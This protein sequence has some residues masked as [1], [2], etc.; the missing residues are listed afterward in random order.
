MQEGQWTKAWG[1][2]VLHYVTR[3]VALCGAKVQ[4]WHDYERD[5]FIYSF[6]GVPLCKKCKEK[7]NATRPPAGAES[8]D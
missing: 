3:K 7:Y 2:R 5:Y 4:Y 8:E 6:W 1:G